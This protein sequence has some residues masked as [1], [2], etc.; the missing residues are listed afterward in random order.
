[1]LFWA[2]PAL[3]AGNTVVVVG[4][5]TDWSPLGQELISRDEGQM[6]A[7]EVRRLLL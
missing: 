2:R 1:M 7:R 3:G 6:G 4:S 5:K